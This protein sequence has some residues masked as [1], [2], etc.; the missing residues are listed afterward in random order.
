MGSKSGSLAGWRAAL[1]VA[2]PLPQCVKAILEPRFDL[3]VLPRPDAG[4]VTREIAEA[5]RGAAVMG[6]AGA[7]FIEALP[8]LEI[9]SS[10]GVGYDKVDV[11]AAL[12]KNIV[13]THTPD[14]LNEE[15]ADTAIG[16]LLNTLRELP[17]AEAF[18]REG[19]WLEGAFPLTRGT[20]RGRKVGIYGLGRIG[21]AIARR[22]DAFGV[23]VSYHNRKPVPDVSWHWEPTLLGL[24]RSVDTLVCV[25]P[26]GPGTEH[27]VNAEILSALGANGVLINIGR[28]STVDEAVLA[29][30]LRSD[31]I[32]AAGLDVF[33]HEPRVPAELLDLPNAC[34][35]P[36][37]G[38]STIHTR[39]LMG[40]LV[41]RNLVNWFTEGR[42]VT[43]IPECAGSR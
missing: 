24:A 6:G 3:F 7:P 19:R 29:D 34:L 33:E 16:L 31:V 11:D 41:A 10:L 25:V 8:Q 18:L 12:A 5:A 1:I 38:S 36:H 27:A 13:V 4:L 43:P 30:A 20:L 26:G 9:I 28:G 14:I 35:L 40:E 39:H 17:R 42:A 32:L 2:G 21:Q 23:A 15:V 22:L 37:V